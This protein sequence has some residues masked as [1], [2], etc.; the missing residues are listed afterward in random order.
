MDRNRIRVIDSDSFA[1][2]PR[3]RELRIEENGLRSLANLHL[4]TALQALHLGYNR[5]AEAADLDRLDGERNV[6][7]GGKKRGGERRGEEKSRR[8][9]G[10]KGGR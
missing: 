2:L 6:W 4:L 3:L 9:G 10:R 8:E 5:I 7:R 1:G